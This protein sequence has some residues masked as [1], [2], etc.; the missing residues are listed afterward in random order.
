MF[1]PYAQNDINYKPNGNSWLQ[2]RL[3]GCHHERSG[4]PYSVKKAVLEFGDNYK[5]RSGPGAAPI[6]KIP[7]LAPVKHHVPYDRYVYECSCTERSYLTRKIHAT[8]NP[9]HLGH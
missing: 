7:E 1:I 6:S 3:V 8:P 5:A 4:I 9:V 2:D